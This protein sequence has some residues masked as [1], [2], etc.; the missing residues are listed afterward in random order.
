[1]RSKA[2]HHKHM[3]ACFEFYIYNIDN[4][5]KIRNF[6]TT[7]LGYFYNIDNVVS[8]KVRKDE[9]LKRYCIKLTM[10]PLE[11]YEDYTYRKYI[12]EIYKPRAEDYK[13]LIVHTCYHVCN[14]VETM[15]DILE[16][17]KEIINSIRS[18]C[19]QL[20]LEYVYNVFVYRLETYLKYN[21]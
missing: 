7:L 17:F 20:G 10:Y 21:T 5:D 12:V 19:K 3:K 13:Y 11:D 16:N 14:R 18:T 2:I 15:Q 6:I 8:I 1:M 9:Y 4:D